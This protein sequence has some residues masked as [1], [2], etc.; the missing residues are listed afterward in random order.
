MYH[1]RLIG[2]FKSELNVT[3]FQTSTG[4]LEMEIISEYTEHI[5]IPKFGGKENHCCL[6][7]S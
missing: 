5:R 4:I 1:L 2:V 6:K 7:G 3:R